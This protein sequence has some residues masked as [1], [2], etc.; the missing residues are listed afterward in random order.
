MVSSTVLRER[1]HNNRR[2][3]ETRENQP[4]APLGFYDELNVGPC[5]LVSRELGAGGGQ[6]ATKLAERLG[7][8]HLDKEIIE[9]LAS[10]YGTPHV[11]LDA[12]DE[13][14]VGWLA[15]LLN[16]W[17]EGHGFSQL[18]YVNR[19]GRLFNMA[20]KRG[21]VV[22]VGRG[23]KF[24]LPK[25]AGFSVRIV[26]PFEFRIEQIVLR[27]GVTAQEARSLI[28]KSD[29]DRKAFINRYFH[30]DVT[31]PHVHDLVVNIKQITPEFAV[32]LIFDAVQFW[33][34]R[35][36]FKPQHRNGSRTAAGAASR[37][38]T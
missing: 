19:L 3:Q 36:G 20:A 1:I 37:T 18:S 29:T 5:L 38:R 10:Q 14:K 31:D 12:V 9:K 6:I 15:D 22:I 26:A 24:L 17:I 13:K 33:L 7:W 4:N 11:I 8:A 16:G 2:V 34:K 27:R 30:H 23:A 35:S 32:H 28:H 25:A 21:N